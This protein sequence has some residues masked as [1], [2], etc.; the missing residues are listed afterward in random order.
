[1]AFDFGTQRIGTAY[2]QS[3]TGT[4]QA[5]PVIRARDGIPDWAALEALIKKWQPALLVVGVPRNLD[6]TQTELTRRAEKFARRLEGRLHL[7]CYGI[8]E[9]L[10]SVAAEELS[11]R[12]TSR[13][14]IDSLAAQVILETWFSE[15]IRQRQ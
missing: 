3:L 14:A 11:E 2:G 13:A 12:G 6:D 7:P 10:S 9:R 5:L 1:M 8:D 15:L 4:A